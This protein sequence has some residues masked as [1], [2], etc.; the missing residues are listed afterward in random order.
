VKIGSAPDFVKE[1]R[2]E[3]KLVGIK[4]FCAAVDYSISEKL[5]DEFIELKQLNVY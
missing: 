1:L 5:Q 3:E 2:L 4:Y